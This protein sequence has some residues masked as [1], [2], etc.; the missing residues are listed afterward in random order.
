[1]PKSP[2]GFI[3]VFLLFGLLILGILFLLSNQNLLYKFI[4]KSQ[5]FGIKDIP[6][7]T[8]DIKYQ[9]GEEILIEGIVIKNEKGC[10]VD[11]SCYLLVNLDGEKIRVTYNNGEWPPCSNNAAVEQGFTIKEND[12]V[13]VFGK[14]TQGQINTCNSK[15]YYI[16]KLSTPVQYNSQDSKYCTKDGDCGLLVCGGCFNA[17]WLESAPPDLACVRFSGFQCKCENN[18]CVESKQ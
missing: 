5:I 10:I 9:E 6:K 12:R 2:K 17:D 15:N 3:L 14:F 8:Q 11:A 7:A 1:M 16:T 13:K 18:K 4:P